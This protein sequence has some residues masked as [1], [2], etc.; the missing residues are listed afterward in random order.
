MKPTEHKRCGGKYEREKRF[1]GVYLY[2]CNRCGKH[3]STYS[4][5]KS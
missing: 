2:T 5:K 3:Y 1:D 4:K